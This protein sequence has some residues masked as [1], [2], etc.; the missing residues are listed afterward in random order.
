MDW[1]VAQPAVYHELVSASVKPALNVG[2]SA[3]ARIARESGS[4]FFRL[5]NQFGFQMSDDMTTT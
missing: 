4:F 5:H 3:V 2:G 1:I